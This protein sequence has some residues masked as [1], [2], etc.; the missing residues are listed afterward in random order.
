MWQKG[1]Y[2]PDCRKS[3]DNAK[4]NKRRSG[5]SRPDSRSR[6]FKNHKSPRYIFKID[7]AQHNSNKNTTPLKYTNPLATLITQSSMGKSVSSVETIRSLNQNLGFESK[8]NNPL[9]IRL[10]I[11]NVPV[12]GE[13]DS[14]ASCSVIS[15]DLIRY[16]EMTTTEII[17]HMALDLPDTDKNI[18]ISTDASDIAV[19]GVI[20]QE[21]NPP[22]PPGTPLEE[23]RVRPESFYSRLLNDSQQ[24][25]AAIQKELYAILLILTESSLESFLLSRHLTIFTDH[26]NL[27]Y[28]ISAPEKNR[29]V[30]RWIPIFSE[31][32]FEIEHVAGTNNQW[33]D[34]LSRV[35][36]RRPV[37]TIK[38]LLISNHTIRNDIILSHEGLIYDEADYV[39]MLPCNTNI[40]AIKSL[41]DLSTYN[42]LPLFDSWLSTIRA[43]QHK[44]INEGDQLFHDSTLCTM[45]NV[46]INSKNKILIPS[47][48]RT[49]VFYM[50]HGL[51]QSGH[52]NKKRSLEILFNSGYFWPSMKADMVKHVKQCPACQKTAP[53]PKKIIESTGSLWADR[54]FARLNV[55]TIGPLPKDQNGNQ[56]L[57]VFVDSFTRYT[58][59]SPLEELNSREVAYRLVWDVIAIFGIPFSIHSDNGTE[60]ANAI[61]EAICNLLA[62]EVSRSIPHFSQSNGLVERRHRDVLQ[63]LRRLLVDFNDYDN[64]S[65]YIPTVQLQIN[66]TNSSVTGHSP[67]ELMFGSDISPGADP[68]NLLAAVEKSTKNVPFI[69]DIKMKLDRL[70]KK[71]EEAEVRQSRLKPKKKSG[72]SQSFNVGDLVLKASKTSKL[73]GNYTG[74]YL[75]VSIDS[76]SSVS[77]KNLI[78]G[79]V[80]KTSIYQCKIFQSGLPADHDLHRAIASGDSEEH[81]VVKILDRFNTPDGEH[82]TVLWFGGDTSSVPTKD[83]KNTNAYSEF[84]KLENVDLFCNSRNVAKSKPTK[85]KRTSSSMS[86]PKSSS[87]VKTPVAKRTRS[88]RREKRYYLDG[89]NLL[90]SSNCRWI[91]SAIDLVSSL[92][93]EMWE[94]LFPAHLKETPLR[95]NSSLPSAVCKLQNKLTKEFELLDFNNRISL[96]KTNSPKF[97]AFLI[98]LCNSGPSVYISQI[99]KVFGLHL[100]DEAWMINMRLHMND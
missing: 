84:V 49:K 33:A 65:T 45:S 93:P 10:L 15:Q 69:N 34:M 92:S 72:P 68:S 6:S 1:H 20:W 22:A 30:K 59:L 95:N 19:G 32:D 40:L 89:I 11:N 28:L 18:I 86:I 73:H 63:S 50:L 88:S 71:R 12:V 54:P 91:Q 58:I 98:D 14:A 46:Y 13:F 36:D 74:P 16:C 79:Y 5:D 78:T 90:N 44:A 8:G 42:K 70:T 61:F 35:I 51:V 38:S 81:I 99:P 27:A 82:C 64:W 96:A 23:R 47:S 43:E 77:L 53:V 26:R 48:L 2:A 94:S 85:L 76:K 80:S 41:Q 57:L 55:D 97:A 9:C 4:S 7:N 75:V 56:F 66:A 100:S 31:F 62:I 67:Y 37:E 3:Q 17:N 52:P 87:V 21:E 39:E 60:F 25:W 29:I 83:I 24:I